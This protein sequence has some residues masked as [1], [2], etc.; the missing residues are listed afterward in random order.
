MA[1][2]SQA[3]QARTTCRTRSGNSTAPKRF[4]RGREGAS[5]YSCSRGTLRFSHLRDSAGLRASGEPATAPL[6]EGMVSF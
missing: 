3:H 6:G 5:R 1:A 2:A 4:G